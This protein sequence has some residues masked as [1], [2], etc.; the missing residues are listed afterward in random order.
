MSLRRLRLTLGL[1]LVLTMVIVGSV[2]SV[3]FS[4]DKKFTI[5][6]VPGITTDSFY[7]S[8]KVGAQAEADR[9]GVNLIW[10]GAPEWNYTKQTQI[11]NS[12]LARGGIDA[13]IIAPTSTNAMIEPIKAVVKAGIPV[14]A[15]DTSIDDKSLLIS[16]ITSDNVQG[17]E[18]AADMLAKMIGQ[19]GQVAVINTIP[20]ITTTDMRQDGFLNRIKA[21]YPNIDVVSIQYCNDRQTQASVQIQQILLRYPNLAGVFATN[22]IS[23]SGVADGL[24]S[25]NAIGKVKLIAYDA[26]PAEVKEL[27]AGNIQGLVVQ[28]PLEEGRLAVEFA[29]KYLTGRGSEIPKRVILP[30][31]VA[32]QDNMNE[33]EVNKYFYIK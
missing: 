6:F 30:N 27:K 9:L 19:K 7:I 10:Q 26:E 23:G 2:A 20:G 1:G 31:V 12:L 16:E 13:M 17:G 33:P 4:A 24:R 11:L 29:Y 8:M 15:V 5:A 32:S 22:V 25:T 28:K 3:G 21:K 14:I 18:A